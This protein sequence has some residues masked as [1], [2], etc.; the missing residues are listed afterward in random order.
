MRLRFTLGYVGTA[1]AG[2]QVQPDQPT[3]QGELEAAVGAVGGRPAAVT[4]ASRT[5]AGVH[6][7]GQVAHLDPP[8]DL[9]PGS[10]RDALNAHLPSDVRV[11]GCD[12]V[13]AAFHARHD[14][15]RKT[16]RYRLCLGE[17][18]PPWL[19]PWAWHVGGLDLEAMAAA[20]DALEGDVDQRTFATRP[21]DRRPMRPLERVEVSREALPTI[22]DGGVATVTVVG[23]SFLRQ[24]VRGIV[25]T[26]VEVGRGRR[27]VT[28]LRELALSG[29]RDAAGPAAPAHGL[30]LERVDY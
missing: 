2:W 9:E 4:G 3:V 29:D 17:V 8:R 10:W 12:A 13:G 15:R 24:A 28:G 20:A 7:C 5:D 18:A 16:Y 1:Y 6:A 21:D 23:R 22:A 30:W 26:L 27:K 25:G 19:S 11:L 14:A